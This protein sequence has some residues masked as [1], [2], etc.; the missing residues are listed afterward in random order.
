[1]LISI[2][3]QLLLLQLLLLQLLLLQLLLLQLRVLLKLGATLK[4]KQS[5]FLKKGKE[6]EEEEE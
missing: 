3:L 1:M 5:V 4:Q 2:L 6:Q